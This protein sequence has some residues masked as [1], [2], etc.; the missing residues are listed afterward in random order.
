[1]QS[2]PSATSEH[3][4]FDELLALAIEREKCAADIYEKAATLTRG[5]FRKLLDAYFNRLMEE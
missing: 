2:M 3:P 1:M 4:G 5:E